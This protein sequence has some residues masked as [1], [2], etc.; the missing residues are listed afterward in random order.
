MDDGDDNQQRVWW[1]DYDVEGWMWS[2]WD[3]EIINLILKFHFTEEEK[4]KCNGKNKNWDGFIV[5]IP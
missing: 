5:L 4:N 2:E 3:Q 1:V